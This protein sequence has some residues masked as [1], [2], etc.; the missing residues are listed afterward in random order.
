MC[1]PKH[2]IWIARFIKQDSGRHKFG[3]IQATDRKDERLWGRELENSK[4]YFLLLKLFYVEVTY[5]LFFLM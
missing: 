3:V 2:R 4:V 5:N 1:F